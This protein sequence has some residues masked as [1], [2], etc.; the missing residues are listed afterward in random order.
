MLL[1]KINANN[2]RYF[3]SW[4]LRRAIASAQML[5]GS[6]GLHVTMAEVITNKDEPT[7]HKTKYEIFPSYYGQVTSNRQIFLA[8]R[9][10]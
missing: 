10:L 6:P 3:I 2:T 1:M 9:A 7:L 4:A 5:L 8:G